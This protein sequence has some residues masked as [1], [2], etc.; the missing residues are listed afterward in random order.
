MSIKFQEFTNKLAQIEKNLS[1]IS[2]PCNRFIN[3]LRDEYE[4]YDEDIEDAKALIKYFNYG[5]NNLNNT[6]QQS[7]IN[8]GVLRTIHNGPKFI[9]LIVAIEATIDDILDSTNHIVSIC[10]NLYA[11][12]IQRQFRK[13]IYQPGKSGYNR[14]KENYEKRLKNIS[15]SS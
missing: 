10:K 7:M 11:P 13:Y 1:L 4:Y 5:I 9:D 3:K 12:I 14:S 8:R 2:G 6:E 15:L